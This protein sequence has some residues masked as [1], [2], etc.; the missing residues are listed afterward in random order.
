MLRSC[1]PRGLK[2]AALLDSDNA[3]DQAAKQDI[4]VHIL[5]NKRIL[6]TNDFMKTPI[7]GAEIEDLLR[8]TLVSV[9]KNDL[10]WD[11]SDKATTQVTRPDRRYLSRRGQ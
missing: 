3:G 6:R 11:I 5:G 8:E 10:D 7:K 2:V 4:L 9:A 1:M